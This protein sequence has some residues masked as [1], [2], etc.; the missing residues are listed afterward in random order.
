MK[1]LRITLLTFCP[2]LK[3]VTEHQ[4]VFSPDSGRDDILVEVKCEDCCSD[5]PGQFI[6]EEMQCEAVEQVDEK[7]GDVNRDSDQNIRY[8]A[9]PRQQVCEKR[10]D[11]EVARFWWEI[12][13]GKRK[14]VCSSTHALC[15]PMMDCVDEGHMFPTINV[16]QSIR[17]KNVEVRSVGL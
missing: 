11:N 8:G 3:I 15:C 12:A 10:E 6:S 17:S 4:G 2:S 14:V 13:K 5:L 1:R 16:V 7:A 9:A